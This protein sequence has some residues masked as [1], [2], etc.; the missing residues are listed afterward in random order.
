[1][2]RI[3]CSRFPSPH[4]KFGHRTLKS[5]YG[6]RSLPG[7]VAVGVL[8]AL[9]IVSFDVTVANAATPTVGLGTAAPFAV[10]AGSAIT[11]TGSSVISGNIGLSPGTSIVGFPPGVQSTGVTE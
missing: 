4:N 10:L 8:C 1:M 6:R 11:N 5:R 3:I 2:L 9:T 7:A